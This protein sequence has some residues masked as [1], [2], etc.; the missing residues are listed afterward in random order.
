MRRATEGSSR[1]DLFSGVPWVVVGN[2]GY[3]LS[4]AVMTFIL[5]KFLTP[6]EFGQWQLYQFYALYLG[7]ITFGYS[8]GVLLRL[9]GR[10]LEKYPRTQLS[11]GLGY[12]VVLEFFSFGA[13]CVAAY[14]LMEFEAWLVFGLAIVGCLFFVPRVLITFIFQSAAKVQHVALTTVLERLVLLAAFV[15]FAATPSLG[16]EFLLVSDVVGKV[17]GFLV[18]LYLARETLLRHGRDRTN[19]LRVFY[20]DCRNGLFVVASNLSAI[21]LNGGARFIIGAIFGT[22]VFGQ[23]SFALQVATVVLVVIN[24]VATAVFPNLR[25]MDRSDYARVYTVLNV[26]LVAPAALLLLASWPLGWLLR[27]WIPDYS[28]AIELMVLLF[29]VGYFEVKSRGSL[30]VLMKALRLERRMMVINVLAALV[31]AGSVWIVAFNTND[32]HLAMLSFVVALALRTYLMSWVV[33]REL[34]I[35]PNLAASLELILVLLHYCLYFSDLSAWAWLLAGTGFGG[36]LWYW[37]R[38]VRQRTSSRRTL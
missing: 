37:S 7:Y 28:L 25:R 4:M 11:A 18:S 23:L 29:P 35:S 6:E 2:A 36:Y 12:L 34:G 32:V 24:A 3:M 10:P 22:V 17:I 16:L 38:E 21:A 27:L 33:E 1:R 20:I 9:A 8:D 5:P 15:L 13:I 26:T 14:F 31:G 30:A 19:S